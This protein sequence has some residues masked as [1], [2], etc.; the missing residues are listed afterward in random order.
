MTPSLLLPPLLRE[1]GT[2][3]LS[4][5]GNQPPSLPTCPGLSLYI[6]LFLFLSPTRSSS[7]HRSLSLSSSLHLPVFAPSPASPP[8]LPCQLLYAAR[9]LYRERAL[10]WACIQLRSASLWSAGETKH[11]KAILFREE[12]FTFL[13][14]IR[15]RAGANCCT[16]VNAPLIFSV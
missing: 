3:T 16:G 10:L 13:F 9:P 12:T 7:L 1:A 4:L 5:R 14:H 15:I 6:P 11:T 2:H 8:R